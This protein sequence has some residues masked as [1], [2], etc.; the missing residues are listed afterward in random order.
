MRASIDFPKSDQI[1]A[2]RRPWPCFA[3]RLPGTGQPAVRAVLDA[4][5]I[6]PADEAAMLE[7]FGTRRLTDPFVLRPAPAA[8]P[9]GR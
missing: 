7:R 6:D 2:S 3:V 9:C 1:Y 8:G 4:E 5:G